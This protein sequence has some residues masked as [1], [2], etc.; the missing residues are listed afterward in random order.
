MHS[1]YTICV[2]TVYMAYVEWT[3]YTNTVALVLI[4]GHPDPGHT[5]GITG[6]CLFFSAPNLGSYL[7]LD[8]SFLIIRM[9]LPDP[10]PKSL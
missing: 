2:Y 6:L 4:Y 5:E 10:K 8:H 7:F 9:P 1:V 3:V